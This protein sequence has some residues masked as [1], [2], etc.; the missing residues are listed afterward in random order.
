M[1]FI[2]LDAG[3]RHELGHHANYARSILRELRAKKIDTVVIGNA[4]VVQELQSEL[5]AMPHFRAYAQRPIDSDPV[6][7]WLKTFEA[8]SQLTFDDLQ[9]IEG[10]APD[11]LH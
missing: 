1:R 3:L 7:G 9:R 8:C 11:D 5:G 6:I 4:F 2:Y 10:I